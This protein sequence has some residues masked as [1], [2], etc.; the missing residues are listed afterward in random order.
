MHVVTFVTA[1]PWCPGCRHK[2]T[3]G[4]CAAATHSWAARWWAQL[5][6]ERTPPGCSSHDALEEVRLLVNG[7]RLVDRLAPP[8]PLRRR[9]GRSGTLG[10]SLGSEEASRAS[11]H[12]ATA[13]PSEPQ[14]SS[15][16][17][18]RAW[19]GGRG[20][21]A[22]PADAARARPRVAASLA[23][24]GARPESRCRRHRGAPHPGR[25]SR[26]LERW[27]GLPP[28]PP[29]PPA[30]SPP[31]PPRRPPPPP[32]PPRPSPRLDASRER[33]KPP[34]DGPRHHAAVGLLRSRSPLGV[35]DHSLGSRMDFR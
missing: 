25:S 7:A 27:G 17:C 5:E 34:D 19:P 22:A 4:G 14:Q 2:Q 3:R 8:S 18:R 10:L 26:D 20:Q 13:L 15:E 12:W 35:P 31:L 11:L 32:P 24:G 23:R 16:W 1:L 21:G 30:R 29:G 9:S 33:K 28:P 6:A